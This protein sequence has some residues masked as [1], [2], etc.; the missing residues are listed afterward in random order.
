VGLPYPAIPL[1]LSLAAGPRLAEVLHL[2]GAWARRP[3]EQVFNPP[4]PSRTYEM[5]EPP[6]LISR[7]A[8]LA[9]AA[10]LLGGAI[11]APTLAGVLAGCARPLEATALRAGALTAEQLELVAVLGEHILPNTDTPG[12]RAAGVHQFIDVMLAEYYPAEERDRFLAGLARVDG[13]ARRAHGSPFLQLAEDRQLA[14]VR[15]L[16]RA[17]FRDPSA[18]TLPE[19][20][21]VLQETDVET[22]RSDL[23]SQRPASGGVMTNQ[24]WDPEDV[25]RQSFFRTLKELTLVGYYTSEVGATQE[26]RLNPMG[27]WRADIPYAEVG[28]AWV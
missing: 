20:E 25:G 9:R 23:E 3:P 11:S 10:A 26:L 1:F 17:A 2:S 16:N 15:A 7:R 28:Q 4:I 18:A 13:Y 19:Q 5:T 8:A 6:K 12:A 21:P 22:G 24:R 27:V 14:L